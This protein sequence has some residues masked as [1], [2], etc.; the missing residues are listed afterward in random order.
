MTATLSMS[1]RERARPRRALDFNFRT[2]RQEVC[3]LLD[4]TF[5]SAPDTPSPVYPDR[6]IRPL[7]RRTLRSRLS[8]DAADTIHYPPTPR[9]PRSSTVS[10]TP[11]RWPRTGKLMPGKKP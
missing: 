3:W 10:E 5:N 9:H 11:K 8:I 7:P 6:L 1:A 2:T 4:G